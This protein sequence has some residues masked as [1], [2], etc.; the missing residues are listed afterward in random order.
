MALV[1][2]LFLGVMLRLRERVD[3]RRQLRPVPDPFVLGTHSRRLALALLS[4]TS[5]HSGHPFAV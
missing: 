5:E 2:R 4:V 1:L 3:T